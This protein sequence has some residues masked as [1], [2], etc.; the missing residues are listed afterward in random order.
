MPETGLERSYALPIE[1]VDGQRHGGVIRQTVANL[2]PRVERIRMVLRH[3]IRR[4]LRLLLDGGGEIQAVGHREPLR[5]LRFEQKR[6]RFA[7]MAGPV[8]LTTYRN[9][10]PFRGMYIGLIVYKTICYVNAYDIS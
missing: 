6:L 5:R 9:L 4:R 2:R 1:T 3:R 10:P 8:K 7:E